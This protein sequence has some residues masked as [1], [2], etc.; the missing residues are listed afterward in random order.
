M[1]FLQK[2][3]VAIAVMVLAIL[4]AVVI[5]QMKKPDDNLPPALWEAIPM[6]MTIP[7]S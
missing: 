7:A 2:R 6:Y 4:C 1:K 5:G 3:T